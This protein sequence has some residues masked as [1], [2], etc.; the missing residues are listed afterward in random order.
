MRRT[1][2]LAA[3]VAAVAALIAGGCSS[4]QPTTTEP[5]TTLAAVDTSAERTV[6]LEFDGDAA[7]VDITFQIGLTGDP[8]QVEGKAVPLKITQKLSP[9]TWVYWSGQNTG[10]YG[11]LTCRITVDGEVVKETT[12][13]GGFVIATC[14]A[15]IPS[16]AP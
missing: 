13:S 15:E 6:D 12:S 14:T 8:T 7:G 10:E 1:G 3:A 9:G 4:N 16:P 5:D 2:Y 11:D